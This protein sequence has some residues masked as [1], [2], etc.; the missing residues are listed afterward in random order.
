MDTKMS[1]LIKENT[2]LHTELKI[3]KKDIKDNLQVR[4]QQGETI[5]KGI[6]YYG[7]YYERVEK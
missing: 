3:L 1:K 5:P 2:K 4:V 7:L 6:W